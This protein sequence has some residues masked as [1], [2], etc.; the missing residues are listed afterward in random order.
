MRYSANDA[1]NLILLAFSCFESFSHCV[2]REVCIFLFVNSC[3]CIFLISFV[4]STNRQAD[5]TV[6]TVNTGELSFNV[7]AYVQNQSGIFNAVTGSFRSAQV[8]FNAVSQFYGCAFRVNCSDFTV[9]DCAF[10]VQCNPVVERIFCELFN[11]REIRS[12]SASTCRTTA[13]ISSPFLYS[14]TASSPATFGRCQ[15]GEPGHRCRRPG[16]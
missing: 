1:E 16:R 11:A 15:T 8:T 4:F 6:L 10:L 5:C 2:V 9:Y 7:V 3:D 14:R 12:R 13:A